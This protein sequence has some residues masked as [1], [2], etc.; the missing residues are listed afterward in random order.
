VV[1]DDGHKQNGQSLGSV[2]SQWLRD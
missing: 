2:R 1:L